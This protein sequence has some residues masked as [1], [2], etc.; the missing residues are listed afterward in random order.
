MKLEGDWNVRIEGDYIFHIQTGNQLWFK[1]DGKELVW[2]N[3]HKGCANKKVKM[4]LSAGVHRVE[5]VTAF[6]YEHRVPPV[7]VTVPGS[8]AE[9]AL[10]DLAATNAAP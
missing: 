4:H 10:D 7:L 1:V 8:A 2:I 3:A 9:V 5:L 6:A